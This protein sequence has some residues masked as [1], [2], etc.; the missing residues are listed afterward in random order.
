LQEGPV[1]HNVEELVEQYFLD[2]DVN[3]RMQV[4]PVAMMNEAL[5]QLLKGDNA[6]FDILLRC[7][8]L[9]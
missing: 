6:A 3:K 4:L 7:I 1:R 5:A 8:Q 2:C 9:I